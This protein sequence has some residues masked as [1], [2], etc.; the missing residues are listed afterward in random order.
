MIDKRAALKIGKKLEGDRVRRKR[1]DFFH[2]YHESEIVARF[3]IRHGTRGAH[4]HIP[5][6]LHISERFALDLAR[7][8]KSRQDWLERMREIGEIGEE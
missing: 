2:V 3:G 7:C 1:H 8:P 4:N 6:Q 5:R